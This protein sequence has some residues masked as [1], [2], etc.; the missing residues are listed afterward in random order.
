MS[1]NNIELFIYVQESDKVPSIMEKVSQISGV[2]KTHLNQFVR[3]IVDVEYDP[4]SISSDAIV[5]TLNRKGVRV[6]LVGM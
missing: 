4:Q 6:A 3:P 1:N 5:N 2:T